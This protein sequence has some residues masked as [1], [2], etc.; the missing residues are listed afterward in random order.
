M[1]VWT[2]AWA[3]VVD[4]EDEEVRREARQMVAVCVIFV[5]IDAS[6][7]WGTG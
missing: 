2:M 4:F 1:L 3:H 6:I 5:C 7:I